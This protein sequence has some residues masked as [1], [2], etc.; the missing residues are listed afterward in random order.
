MLVRYWLTVFPLARR[1]L[2]RWR[3]AAASIPDPQLRRMALS[4]LSEEHLNAEG[5]ALFATLAPWRRTPAVV[6]AVVAYQ[7]LYDFLDTLTESPPSGRSSRGASP[8]PADAR[9]L[10]LALL[11][12]LDP[13]RPL[14]DWY[15]LRPGAGD[16]GYL[17]ALVA[18]CRAAV[19]RLPAYDAV[20][21]SALRC[22]R[23]SR[24][25]QALNHDA[26]PA[27]PR[28]LSRWALR[29]PAA[30]RLR[31]WECA[32]SSSSSLG[33]HVLI[34]LAAD[35][36]TT[37][38]DARAAE[39]SYCV[40]FGALNTLLESLVDLPDDLRSGE[41]SLVSYYAGPAETADR[42]GLVAA[43]ARADAD[44]LSRSDRHAVI[45][46]GMV[47]FYLSCAEAWLPDARPAADRT[48][49]AV[50]PPTAALVR[51]LRVRRAL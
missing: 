6:R 7:V 33:V 11:D 43:A 47:G 24:E 36:G 3:A 2:R 4:T 14:S 41:H 28:E 35:R 5:A 31:W 19:A 13:R 32:A 17:A 20:A 45:L 23:L 26:G 8:D 22:A 51:V 21:P 46:A 30:D 16:G 15:A 50:G 9:Q 10:H 37:A 29:H 27:R 40:S 18:D 34:G 39:R 48:L 49:A 42:L 1:A 12:A 44:G 25:V 38:A